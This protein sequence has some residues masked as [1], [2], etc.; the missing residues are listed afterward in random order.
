[1]LNDIAI[2]LTSLFITTLILLSTYSIFLVI[3]YYCFSNVINREIIYEENYSLD[4]SNEN[5]DENLYIESAGENIN[6]NDSNIIINNEGYT[7]YNEE[8]L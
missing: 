6:I 7:I 1:M 2:F 5:E 8:E 3:E 4:L